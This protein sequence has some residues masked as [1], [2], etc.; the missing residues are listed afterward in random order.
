[1]ICAV[2]ALAVELFAFLAV[3]AVLAVV[4]LSAVLATGCDLQ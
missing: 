2:V 4:A 3:V 1:M